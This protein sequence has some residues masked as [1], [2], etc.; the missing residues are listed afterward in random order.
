MEKGT[1]LITVTAFEGKHA[2]NNSQISVEY[3]E[4]E[5]LPSSLTVGINL[6]DK[7][8]DI[9]AKDA[10]GHLLNEVA[11]VMDKT[12]AN[13]TVLAGNSSGT[14]YTDEFGEATIWFTEVGDILGSF[15]AS[16]N[17]ANTTGEL[18]I[19]WPIF[20][21]NPEIIYVGVMNEVL[22]KAVDMDGNPIEG[23]NLTLTP[24]YVGMVAGAIPDPIATDET[25]W[26]PT[27]LS[28][29][30]LA[31]GTLN[32]TIA[33]NIHYDAGQLN[34]YSL[35]TDTVINVTSKKPL[36][37]T[38]S[39]SPIYQGETLT[40]TVK[41]E[42]IAV[43]DVDIKFGSLTGKTDANGEVDFAVPDPGVESA[44]YYIKA[45]KIGYVTTEI[46]ISVIKKYAISIDVPDEVFA[47][48][49][50][51]VT[52]IAKGQPL[53]GATVTLDGTTT[54]MSGGDGK[55]TFTAGAKD[56]TH[57]IKAVFAP[58]TDGQATVGPVKE[59]GVPGFELLTLVIAI[60][61]AFILLRRRKQN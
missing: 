45:E 22:I 33:Q 43:K 38:A 59:K 60:G 15:C 24:S 44:M 31:S 12:D 47:G 26:I 19:G 53:A 28:V 55:V 41:S 56:A 18:T 36:E 1:L 21:L 4:F 51:T 11:F 58:Y 6:E 9:I 50:F 2:G 14:I 40:V 39:K 27:P 54:K 10:L 20:T 34:W 37:I 61:V 52:I 30:P 25:G 13:D 42:G 29:H 23:I 17:G 48:E 35:L 5:Y 49:S 7:G 32:V 8:V 46:G 3:A 16:I 57:T